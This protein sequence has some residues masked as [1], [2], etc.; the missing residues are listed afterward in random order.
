[1]DNMIFD[2]LIEVIAYCQREEILSID[3]RLYS[4][5][6]NISDYAEEDIKELLS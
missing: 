4:E 6:A 3:E 2:L 1:M 5:L